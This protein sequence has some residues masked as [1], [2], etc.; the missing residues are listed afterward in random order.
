MLGLTGTSGQFQWC[1]E[2]SISK[3]GVFA[4]DAN[5]LVAVDIA[6][7]ITGEIVANIKI[8]HENTY[9]ANRD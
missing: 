3:I 1:E 9:V 4:A 6:T 7:G 2:G 8:V 5:E